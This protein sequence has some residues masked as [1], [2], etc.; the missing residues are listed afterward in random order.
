LGA[1]LWDSRVGRLAASICWLYPSLIFYDYLILTET[2][3]TCLLVA[4]VLASV[5]LVQEPRT[6]FAIA[7]GA[8]LGLAALTRSVLWPLPLL[9]CP[10]LLVVLHAPW[11]RR[12]V[13]AATVLS[14][15]AVVVGPW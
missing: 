7:C 12:L 6:R 4:F 1:S 3:F 9:L 10:A 11:S 14:T 8:T 5:K 13:L 2:L 15:Y